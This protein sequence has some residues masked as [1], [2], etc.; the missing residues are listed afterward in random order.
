[1]RVSCGI[2]K[3]MPGRTAA[4]PFYLAQSGRILH[5]LPK[6]IL[7]IAQSVHP[8]TY[9]KALSVNRNSS[10]IIARELLFP[11]W[12]IFCLFLR[13]LTFE[14]VDRLVR[15]VARYYPDNMSY[16]QAGVESSSISK[17]TLIVLSPH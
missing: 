1:M 3:L 4:P 11:S 7:Y 12:P 2:F 8:Y 14:D 9:N 13:D 10:N 6:V 5:Q 16:S 15:T 17:C